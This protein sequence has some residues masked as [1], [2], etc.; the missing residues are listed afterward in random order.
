MCLLY[1]YIW[2]TGKILIPTA[3]PMFPPTASAIWLEDQPS[4]AAAPW[5]VRACAH[6]GVGIPGSVR[7]QGGLGYGTSMESMVR[8]RSKH[9]GL[10]KRFIL[11][12]GNMKLFGPKKIYDI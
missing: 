12:E 10:P 8:K 6:G 11:S 4:N 9:D 3:L 7:A 5:V 2:S 1:I